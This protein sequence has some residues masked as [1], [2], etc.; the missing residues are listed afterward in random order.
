MWLAML[1]SELCKEYTHRYGKDHKTRS[2]VG[3]F[4]LGLPKQMPLAPMTPFALAM[5]DE[6]KDKDPI[7]AYQNYYLDSKA[8][9]ARWTNRS[10]PK[11]FKDRYKD[12]NVSNFERTT[13]LA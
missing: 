6:L 1:F 2:T 13:S 10:A 11:W 4:L 3:D 5:P 9:I 12:F 8:S 7:R